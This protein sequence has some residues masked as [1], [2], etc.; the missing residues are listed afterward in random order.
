M[1]PC[2]HFNICE[3][4]YYDAYAARKEAYKLELDAWVVRFYAYHDSGSE[5]DPG[6]PKPV[7]TFNCVECGTPVV[8]PIVLFQN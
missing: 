3:H 1:D 6:D 5:E 8:K 7:F 4:C 2:W